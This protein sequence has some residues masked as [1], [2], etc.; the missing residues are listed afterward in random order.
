MELTEAQYDNVECL[1]QM[2]PFLDTE[3]QVLEVSRLF[4]K[5]SYILWLCVDCKLFAE[6]R[7][8]L[9]CQNLSLSRFRLIIIIVAALVFWSCLLN[10]KE[11]ITPN[12]MFNC[13]LPHVELVRLPYSSDKYNANV[14]SL[15][16][17]F[18][19]WFW[20]RNLRLDTTLIVTKL[21]LY[22]INICI[23]IQL[24]YYI[25]DF[26]AFDRVVRCH[27]QIFAGY[28]II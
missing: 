26:A 16:A 12:F 17:Y 15:Q 3:N 18:W 19:W 4:N 25:I 6:H 22:V 11:N 10:V 28:Y 13:K 14:V 1:F 9:I 20:P 7:L 23:N 24:F 8:I 27:L 5:F 2:G 21:D